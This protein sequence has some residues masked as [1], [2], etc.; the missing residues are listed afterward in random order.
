MEAAFPTGTTQLRTRWSGNRRSASRLNSREPPTHSHLAE[1]RLFPRSGGW[2]G[3][4]AGT[5]ARAWVVWSTCRRAVALAR[6]SLDGPASSLV[7]AA[8]LRR[9]QVARHGPCPGHRLRRD[10]GRAADVV[11]G[12]GS[13]L[14]GPLLRIR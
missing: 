6:A 10:L 12:Q 8:Q 9:Q 14:G 3:T 11:E 7:V 5:A 1:L 2:P 13:G 4:R